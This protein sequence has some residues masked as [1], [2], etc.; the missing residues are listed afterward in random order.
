[1]SFRGNDL[2]YASSMSFNTDKKRDFIL[3]TVNGQSNGKFTIL[4]L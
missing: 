2:D 1:M 4:S 3:A